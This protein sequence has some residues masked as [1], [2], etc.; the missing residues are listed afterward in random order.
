MVLRAFCRDVSPVRPEV[1][2]R[3]QA[4]RTER[5]V[6]DRRPGRRHR[7]QSKDLVRLEQGQKSKHRVCGGA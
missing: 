6:K 4:I 7:L 5:K 3:P 1:G 2:R